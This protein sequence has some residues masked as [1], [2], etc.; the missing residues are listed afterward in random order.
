MMNKMKIVP[1]QIRQFSYGRG[2]LVKSS[3]IAQEKDIVV[4]K[5]NGSYRWVTPEE[6]GLPGSSEE[7][8]FGLYRLER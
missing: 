4:K 5:A 7:F 3:E 2:R 1:P 6:V 8:R